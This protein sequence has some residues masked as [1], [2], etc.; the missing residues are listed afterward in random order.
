M[1]TS[2]S[3]TSGGDQKAAAPRSLLGW[4]G[5]AFAVLFV[6]GFISSSNSLKNDAPDAE[7]LKW[8][9]NHGH[10]KGVLVGGYMMTIAAFAFLVLAAGLVERVRE[11]GEASPVLNRVCW[12]TG[13]LAS[14]FML[15]AAISLAGIAGDI[16]FGSSQNVETADLLRHNLGYAILFLTTALTAAVFIACVTTLAR[17]AGV[18]GTAMTWFSYIVAVALAFAVVFL[19]ILALPIWGLVTGIALLRKG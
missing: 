11:A 18:F 10:L 2:T 3:T 1:A 8:Y 15:L 13:L 6:I 12:A 4:A 7:W 17:R 9:A 14:G 5:I 19:P 16:V